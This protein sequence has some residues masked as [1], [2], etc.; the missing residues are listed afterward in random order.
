MPTTALTT[1]WARIPTY[2]HPVLEVLLGLANTVLETLDGP[3]AHEVGLLLAAAGGHAGDRAE[4][5]DRQRFCLPAIRRLIA[6][7]APHGR[8]FR[9]DIQSE[10]RPGHCEHA[11]EHHTDL[12]ILTSPRLRPAGSAMAAGCGRPG[13]CPQPLTRSWSLVITGAQR[14]TPSSC[15]VL[16]QNVIRG[17]SRGNQYA[18]ACSLSIAQASRLVG[19]A[20]APGRGRNTWIV[21]FWE[22][23]QTVRTDR[24]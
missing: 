7:L 17:Q 16:G 6:Y 13:W 20:S 8:L 14:R 10:R 3:T 19:A 4:C 24:R 18:G 21:G 11:A 2:A 1:A 9:A 15:F 23:C 12:L 22:K 5:L